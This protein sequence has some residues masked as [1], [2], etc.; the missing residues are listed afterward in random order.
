[1]VTLNAAAPNRDR[2]PRFHI[3]VR[4]RSRIPKMKRM[5]INAT[6]PEELR[7]AVVDGQKLLNLDIENAAHQQKK[8]NIYKGRITR[9]EASLQAAFVEYGGD[10]QGF[11]PVKEV[12]RE[13]YPRDE[14][15]NTPSPKKIRI[16][17]VLSEGQELIVQVDKEERGSKGAALTT[18][19]SLAG[20]YLVLMPNNPRAGGVS[21]RIEGEERKEMRDA[22]NS[23]EIPDGVGV[24]IRT[25]G[26]GKESDQLQRDLDH[27]LHL[28][29]SIL[30]QSEK[31]P[32]P[33]LIYQEGDMVI[34][35]L[36]DNFEEG[37]GEILV[38]DPEVAGKAR[39]F[40][41]TI[42]PE[43]V[44][45]I[46]VYQDPIPLFSRFQIEHQI[47]TAYSR[48]V[49]L[50]GGGSLVIDPTEALVSI[51]INSAKATKGE[52]LE[53]TALQTNLEAA[54]EIPRQLR[55]RDV[56]GLIVIDFIDMK[57]RR[58]TQQVEDKLRESV[59]SDRARIKVGKISRFGLL[60]MSRQRLR[61]SLGEATHAACPRCGGQGRIRTT[62]SSALHILRVFEEEALKENT[63]FLDARVPVGVAAYLLNEKRG[64]LTRLEE[65]YGVQITVIPDP[66]IE[67]PDYSVERGRAKDAEAQ[68]PRPVSYQQIPSPEP[69]DRPRSETAPSLEEDHSAPLSPTALQQESGKSEPAPEA[70]TAARESGSQREEGSGKPGFLKRILKALFGEHAPQEAS[71]VEASTEAPA[72]APAETPARQAAASQGGGQSRQSRGSRGGQA[73]K[74]AKGGGQTGQKQSQGKEPQQAKPQQAKAQQAKAQQG[75]KGQETKPQGTKAQASGAQETQGQEKEA[76]ASQDGEKKSGEK[77]KSGGGRSGGRRRG[78]SGGS[79]RGGSG[80]KRETEAQKGDQG[81]PAQEKE[82][83]GEPEKAAQGKQK[84]GQQSRGGRGKGGGQP[85]SAQ[86]GEAAEAAPTG[87]RVTPP[88]PSTKDIEVPGHTAEFFEESEA[89]TGGARGGDQA[90][91]RQESASES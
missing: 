51:D 8:G 66:N 35:T 40:M 57:R 50:D 32:A 1:M 69:T 3:P 59:K 6:N 89:V 24:I 43:F 90:A 72:E 10:R 26:I 13:Y 31:H 39:D 45:R 75:G 53:E 27:L 67:T 2:R 61:P 48:E 62:D 73:K 17:D 86:S 22:L 11:L 30:E 18:M 60:E 46:K 47:D 9:I 84:S 19:P 7:V 76:K 56:G 54:E 70:S 20:R 83:K 29:R 5:L 38:D 44:R 49:P 63:A 15:G 87:E 41:Q 78:G 21:R 68:A 14:E 34:R 81:K 36:R 71:G 4:V 79:R 80:Q 64:A 74:G 23:L 12:A 33:R 91:A 16:Q 65:K 58:N 77:A 25:A 88:K 52:D 37:V 85:K 82:K 28:W 55:L 42:M